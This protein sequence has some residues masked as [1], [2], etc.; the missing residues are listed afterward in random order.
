[1]TTPPNSNENVMKHDAVK[2]RA[3]L[4]DQNTEDPRNGPYQSFIAN[5]MHH[6]VVETEMFNNNQFKDKYG[7]AYATRKEESSNCPSYPHKASFEVNSANVTASG[8]GLTG[9]FGIFQA[10]GH[11]KHCESTPV[12]RSL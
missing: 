3:D 12:F 9:T 8:G 4:V 6:E 5:P 1:M 11:E 2:E 7:E 10:D